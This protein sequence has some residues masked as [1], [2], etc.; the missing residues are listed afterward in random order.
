V[1]NWKKLTNS[2]NRVRKKSFGG[3]FCF[4]NS[5]IIR[6][7]TGGLVFLVS[8]HGCGRRSEIHRISAKANYYIDVSELRA[9]IL[10]IKM[11]TFDQTYYLLRNNWAIL[12]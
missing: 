9:D 1:N 12:S 11:A 8:G 5:H 3:T 4:S 10:D 7:D 6:L 2:R